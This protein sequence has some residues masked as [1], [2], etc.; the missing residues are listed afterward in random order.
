MTEMFKGQCLYCGKDAF[1]YRT[2]RFGPEPEIFDTSVCEKNYKY[3]KKRGQ[4]NDVV[5]RN[6]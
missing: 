5:K 2:N 6:I 1:Y 3:D 4:D